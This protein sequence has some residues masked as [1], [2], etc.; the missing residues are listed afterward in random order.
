MCRHPEEVLTSV[1]PYSADNPIELLVA[2]LGNL[3]E[4]RG[5]E[6]FAVNGETAIFIARNPCHTTCSFHLIKN[7]LSVSELDI[8]KSAL[9]AISTAS[10]IVKRKGS[11]AQASW[12]GSAAPWCPLRR[13]SRPLVARRREAALDLDVALAALRARGGLFLALHLAMVA[14]VLAGHLIHLQPRDAEPAGDLAQVLA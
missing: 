9:Q 11:Q 5:F 7:D 13:K 10:I 2:H 14:A 3:G 6:R 1:Q 12:E 4:I 8:A